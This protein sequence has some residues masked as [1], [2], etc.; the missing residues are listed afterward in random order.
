MPYH[1]RRLRRSLQIPVLLI[2]ALLTAYFVHHAI[3]GRHGL[4]ARTRLAERARVLTSEL[5]SLEA[6]RLELSRAV[7][8]LEHEDTALDQIDVVA[9]SALGFAHPADLILIERP[10]PSRPTTD[11]RP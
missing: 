6:V 11:R 9:R 7:A 8:R 4:E 3:H 5:A 2:C 10:Q 1:D